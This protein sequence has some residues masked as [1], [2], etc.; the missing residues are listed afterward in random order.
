MN[1]MITITEETIQPT[2]IIPT[3][4]EHFIDYI[5]VKEVTVKSYGVCLRCFIEWLHNRNIQ[6]P[7]QMDILASETVVGNSV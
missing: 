2:T 4:M 6:H 7:Q 1:E 3:L 5:N